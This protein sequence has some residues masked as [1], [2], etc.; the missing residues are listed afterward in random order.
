VDNNI[1][2]Y[3]TMAISKKNSKVNLK[4]PSSFMQDTTAISIT[5]NEVSFLD[6]SHISARLGNGS[7]DIHNEYPGILNTDQSIN[8]TRRHTNNAYTNKHHQKSVQHPIMTD[9]GNP[10]KSSKKNYQPGSANNSPDLSIEGTSKHLN[11]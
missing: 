5:N 4:E 8:T 9:R 2:T 6:Q 3:N 7:P 11:M 10:F 1:N